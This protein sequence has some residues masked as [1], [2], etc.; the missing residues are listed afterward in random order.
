LLFLIPISHLVPLLEFNHNTLPNVSSGLGLGHRRM[1]KPELYFPGGRKYVQMRSSGGG[2]T[3]SVNG[4]Q[5]LYGLKAAAPDPSGRLNYTA[6]SDGTSSATAL[7]TR[8]AHRIFDALMDRDGGS[9][10][11]DMDPQFYAVTVKCLLV[12]S[13]RWSANHELLKENLRACEW[14]SVRRT[15]RK[16]QSFYRLWRPGYCRCS[17]MR[18]EQSHARRLRDNSSGERA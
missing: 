16:F 12:H 7:A 13:A 3:V 18:S 8:S 17:G 6:F 9:K 14:P 2:L 15:R 5:R 10:L 11:A 1:I 4:P